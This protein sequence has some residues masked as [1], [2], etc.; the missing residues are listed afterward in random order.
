MFSDNLD[1]KCMARYIWFPVYPIKY[2]HI[3]VLF[4]CGYIVNIW[5]DPGH[6]YKYILHGYFPGTGAIWRFS[7]DSNEFH[8]VLQGCFTG[9]GAIIW[10]PQYDCP[11]ACEVILK[12]KLVSTQPQQDTTK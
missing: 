6:L 9:T 1:K 2:A 10:L 8:N 11:S 3:F 12:V 5:L 7:V 4:C